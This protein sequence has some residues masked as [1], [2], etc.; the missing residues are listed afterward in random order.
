MSKFDSD[1]AIFGVF[2]ADIIEGTAI[3]NT[4]INYVNKTCISQY[5]DLRGKTI[6]EIVFEIA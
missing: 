5:G 4:I 6:R 2:T 1:Y 3:S